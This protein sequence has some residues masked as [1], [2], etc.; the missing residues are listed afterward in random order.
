MA[1]MTLSTPSPFLFPRIQ[2]LINSSN[3]GH[4]YDSFQRRDNAQ[5][6]CIIFFTKIKGEGE[7]LVSSHA[8]KSLDFSY[9]YEREGMR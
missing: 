3:L 7:K 4:I 2:K 1:Y 6:C 5:R 8:R 9:T